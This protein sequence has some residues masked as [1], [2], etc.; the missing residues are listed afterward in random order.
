MHEHSF[1]PL[2]V[3]VTAAMVTGILLPRLTM[4][5]IPLVVGEILK[6]YKAKK[7]APKPLQN[8]IV[9]PIADSG[10]APAAAAPSP[11]AAPKPNAPKAETKPKAKP[12]AKRIGMFGRNCVEKGCTKLVFGT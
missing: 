10:A 5:R 1:T 6:K 8:Q 12:A 2:L 3:V 7:E 9:V 11:K 4:L